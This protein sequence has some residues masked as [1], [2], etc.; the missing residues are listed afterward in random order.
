MKRSENRASAIGSRCVEIPCGHKST[1]VSGCGQIAL[2]FNRRR[3]SLR[4]DTAH[5][6]ASQSGP[7]LS[8][9]PS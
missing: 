7:L 1:P 6:I 2:R 4:Q 9:T 5:A 8:S 3:A